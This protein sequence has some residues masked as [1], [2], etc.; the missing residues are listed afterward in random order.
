[1]QFIIAES[2]FL[3]AYS[4][5]ILGDIFFVAVNSDLILFSLLGIYILAV[6]F[7]NIKSK[8]TC[9]VCIGLLFIM[10]FLFVATGTSVSTEKAA[11]WIVM[12]FFLTIIQQFFEI[13]S[14]S[15]YKNIK[16]LRNKYKNHKF[17]KLVHNFIS[18]A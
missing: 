5:F 14:V 8:Y 15:F 13:E 3:T 12:F 2:V 9:M 11:V 16:I 10:Y 7:Y 6:N 18:Q 4:L 1:M 17:T